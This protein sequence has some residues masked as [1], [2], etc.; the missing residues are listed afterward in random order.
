MR[1]F[2]LS[3]FAAFLLS[4]L[5][6]AATIPIDTNLMRRSG[7]PA[8]ESTTFHSTTR[9]RRVRKP[10]HSKRSSAASDRAKRSPS[11]EP[12][13]DHEE[14]QLDLLD[15][16]LLDDG[17]LGDGLLGKRQLPSLPGL[18]GLGGGSGGGG[19]LSITS[20]LTSCTSG[21]STHQAKIQKLASRAKNYKDSPMNSKFQNSVYEE[22]KAYRGSAAGLPGLAQLDQTLK[23]LAPNQGLS[24]FDRGNDIE[25]LFRTVNTSLQDTLESIDLIVFKLPILGPVLGPILYD[26]KCIIDD[27]LNIVQVILDG[28]LNSTGIGSSSSSSPAGLSSLSAT[29]LTSICKM[30]PSLP[31]C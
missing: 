17:L 26:I 6:S 16:G 18:G 28:V 23:P 10:G 8:A 21:M 4:A 30:G 22:L 27:I 31:A 29:Y 11:P 19:L 5:I 25:V 12:L 24:E 3:V 7:A 13:S 1:G 20:V 9:P 14:R 2:R 15:G